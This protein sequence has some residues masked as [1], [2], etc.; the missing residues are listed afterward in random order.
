MPASLA[1]VYNL[2]TNCATLPKGTPCA[3]P[4]HPGDQ[5][6][7]YFTGASVATANGSPTAQPLPTGQVAPSDGSVL[8]KTL[9]TPVV[10]IGGTNGVGGILRY[11]PG[12]RH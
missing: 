9:E 4:A 1:A 7:I 2:P 12:H 11:R 5:I 3:Q 10:T 6:V 8:C